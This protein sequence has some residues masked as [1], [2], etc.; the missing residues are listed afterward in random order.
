MLGQLSTTFMV[1]TRLDTWD[2]RME[3]RPLVAPQHL[4]DD[5]GVSPGQ[6]LNGG[7]QLPKQRR[8]PLDWLRFVRK[9]R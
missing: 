6:A 5:L 3:T 8:N 1:A 4:F 7:K 2:R 9:L